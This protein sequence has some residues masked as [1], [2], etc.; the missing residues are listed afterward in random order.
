MVSTILVLN[1]EEWCYYLNDPEFGA[2]F[3]LTVSLVDTFAW[4]TSENWRNCKMAKLQGVPIRGALPTEVGPLK[5][6]LTDISLQPSWHVPQ[7]WFLSALLLDWTNPKNC[8]IQSMS[9]RQ[10]IVN[11]TYIITNLCAPFKPVNFEGWHSSFEIK[12]MESEDLRNTL[13]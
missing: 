8:L 11:Y 10:I 2:L 9:K 4:H 1:K 3:L 6:S 12:G 13:I 5:S 7:K